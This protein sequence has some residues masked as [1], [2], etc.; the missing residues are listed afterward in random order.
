MWCFA[1][2]RYFVECR[3]VEK[4]EF[5]RARGEWET[6]REERDAEK[7]VDAGAVALNSTI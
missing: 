2:S 6:S 1:L 7:P 4:F 5:E 3:V